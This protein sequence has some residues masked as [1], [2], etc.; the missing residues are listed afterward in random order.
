MAARGRDSPS[1][2][3]DTD[4]SDEYAAPAAPTTRSWR[5]RL[6]QIVHPGAVSNGAGHA[7][8]AAAPPEHSGEYDGPGADGPVPAPSAAL[9]RFGHGS[10]LGLRAAE[11]ETIA[12]GLATRRTFLQTPI[13][14]DAQALQVRAV[15]RGVRAGAGTGSR[16]AL[17]PLCARSAT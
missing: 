12:R 6:S 3:E 1:D 11:D 7:S 4:V 16:T 5:Q 14:E 8:T 10:H 17:T 9:A 13:A 15:A 2:G